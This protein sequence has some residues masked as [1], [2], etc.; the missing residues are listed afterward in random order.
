MTL[1]EAMIAAGILLVSLGIKDTTPEV[2]DDLSEVEVDVQEMTKKKRREYHTRAMR[3]ERACYILRTCADALFDYAMES[4]IEQAQAMNDLR[5]GLLRLIST[6][7]A[8]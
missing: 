5:L 8:A 6:V 2:P 7:E 1:S 4:T 3:K